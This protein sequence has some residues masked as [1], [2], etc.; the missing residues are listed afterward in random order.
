MAPPPPREDPRLPFVSRREE[1]IL[2]FPVPL[3]SIGLATELRSTLVASSL[4]SLRRRSLLDRYR[5]IV[6]PQHKDALLSTVAGL[7]LPMEIGHAHYEAVDKLGFTVEEQADIGA[8]VSHKIHDTF[9]GVVMKM[10]TNAG[11]TP[12]TLL[13]KGNQLYSRLFRGGGGTRV[14]KLGPKEARADLVGIP[15]LTVPYLR[16]AMRGLY[17]AAISVFCTRCYVHEVAR[18]SA[19]TAITLRISWA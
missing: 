7:W 12:W 18:H 1:V 13:P 10:A 9:L 5:E 8:E 14:I 2:G 3:E 17:Q 6:A 16:H 19:P 15:L 11:V 4:E